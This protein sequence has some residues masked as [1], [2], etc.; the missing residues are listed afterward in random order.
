MDLQVQPE[1]GTAVFFENVNPK[2]SE[3]FIESLHAGE[4]VIAGEKWLATLWIRNQDTHRGP[5]YDS[6]PSK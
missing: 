1:K 2:T 5:D 6:I 4:P 3:P